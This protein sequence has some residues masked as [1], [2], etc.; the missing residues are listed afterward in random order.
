[1]E[2]QQCDKKKTP[3]LEETVLMLKEKGEKNKRELCLLKDQCLVTMEYQCHLL[4]CLNDLRCQQIA[5]LQERLDFFR[6]N[7]GQIRQ[8]L[9]FAKNRLEQDGNFDNHALPRQCQLQ[10]DILDRLALELR[11]GICSEIMVFATTLNCM[12]TFCQYCVAQWKNESPA[13]GCP[14]CREPTTSEKRNFLVDNIIAIMVSLNSEDEKFSRKELLKQHE[15]LHRNLLAA[16]IRTPESNNPFY[17][18]TDR[19]LVLG[20]M[21]NDDLSTN[22]EASESLPMITRNFV[23]NTTQT[24]GR[25]DNRRRNHYA[26]LLVNIGRRRISRNSQHTIPPCNSEIGRA[27]DVGV[28]PSTSELSPRIGETALALALLYIGVTLFLYYTLHYLHFL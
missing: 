20:E 4:T 26:R 17:R 11:C 19:G 6:M 12:H 16:G 8:Q 7:L 2:K 9:I 15:V 23:Q 28:L 18:I 1:M 22:T 10:H 13:A 27:P 21:Q 5:E 25:H 3:K 14:V 24:R